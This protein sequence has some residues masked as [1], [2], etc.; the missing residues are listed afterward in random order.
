MVAGR[1]V[2]ADDETRFAGAADREWL[3]GE[4]EARPAFGPLV[5]TMRLTLSRV[6]CC[7]PAGRVSPRVSFRAGASAD[8]GG[9]GVTGAVA[10]LAAAGAGAGVAAAAAGSASFRTFT[11]NRSARSE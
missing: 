7:G 9:R 11:P 2:V 8:R 5:M 3:A 10:A 1:V 6:A 4:G